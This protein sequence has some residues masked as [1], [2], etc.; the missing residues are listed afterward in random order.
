MKVEDQ[1][2]RWPP[3]CDHLD[4]GAAQFLE[5]ENGYRIKVTFLQ[6]VGQCGYSERVC[7]LEISTLLKAHLQRL[8][9][10]ILLGYEGVADALKPL[11]H[12]SS[13]LVFHIQIEIGGRIDIALEKLYRSGS[14]NY[15]ACDR[16]KLPE[17]NDFIEGEILPYE[18]LSV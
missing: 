13:S 8:K 4:V 9:F 14:R 15:R 6:T 10:S 12:R 7:C 3:R 17:T 5:V 11:R 2:Q 1:F 16:L 18:S